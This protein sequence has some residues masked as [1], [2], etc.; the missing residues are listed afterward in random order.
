MLTISSSQYVNEQ[1]TYPCVV[2]F[3]AVLSVTISFSL[4]TMLIYSM[5]V[6]TKLPIILKKPIVKMGISFVGILLLM[7]S[8][9]WLITQFYHESNAVMSGLLGVL[10]G[11]MFV[12]E[13]M[14]YIASYVKHVD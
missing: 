6:T 12:V 8:S 11:F 13:N 4:T 7:S 5:D 2:V 3:W 14:F 10:A 1:A 9:V